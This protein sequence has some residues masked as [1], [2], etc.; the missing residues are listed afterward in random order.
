[1]S[2]RYLPDNEPRDILL[3]LEELAAK[4]LPHAPTFRKAADEITRLRAALAAVTEK[5]DAL[6]A[7]LAP[8]DDDI[9]R[10]IAAMHVARIDGHSDDWDRYVDE[11]KDYIDAIRPHIEAV[12]RERCAKRILETNWV[13]ADPEDIAAAIREGK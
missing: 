5:R 7:H 3:S 10:E 9:L 8:V 12:E 6:A 4:K 11:A 1:M 13:D 2:D